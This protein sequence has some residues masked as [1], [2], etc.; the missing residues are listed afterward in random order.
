MSLKRAL[1]LLGGIVDQHTRIDIHGMYAVAAARSGMLDVAYD[2]AA[3]AA[4]LIGA[5][6]KPTAYAQYLGFDGCAEAFSL[7]IEHPDAK[8][9]GLTQRYN[10]AIGNLKKYAGPFE[11]GAPQYHRHRGSREALQGR[12]RRA[13]AC[14]EIALEHAIALGLPYEEAKSRVLLHHAGQPGHV[15]RASALCQRLELTVLAG[16][17]EAL[18]ERP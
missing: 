7:L 4:D 12:K 1:M 11:I 5:T 13:I 17:C 2:Q 14:W 3:K 16:Q 6:Q 18:Q 10:E 9:Q 15:E 8:F